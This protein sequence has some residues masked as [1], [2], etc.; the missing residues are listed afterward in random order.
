MPGPDHAAAEVVRKLQ[1][2]GV[3]A[4]AMAHY[5]T[6]PGTGRLDGFCAWLEDSTLPHVDVRE[7]R[8]IIA[9]MHD[10]LAPDCEEPIEVG[11]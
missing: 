5:L 4:G 11:S 1:Q 6:E 7:M 9:E 10:V 8:L 3:T 2:A